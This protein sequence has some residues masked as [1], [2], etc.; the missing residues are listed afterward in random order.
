MLNAIRMVWI[1]S[2]H[3]NTDERMVPLLARIAD[4]I[5]IKVSDQIAL[6]RILQRPTAEAQATI[7]QA[8]KVLKSWL[9]NYN[10]TQE[11]ID[12]SSSEHRWQFDKKRLFE[13]TKHLT[14][15]C[16]D[17]KEVVTTL[18]H[19]HRFLGP[20][21][22]SVT[23]ET[24]AIDALVKRV[25][26]LKDPLCVA[27]FDVFAHDIASLRQWDE[28]MVKFR[29]S[30]AEVEVETTTFIDLAFH[31]L[32]SAE[33]AFDLLCGLGITAGDGVS[34][35]APPMSAQQTHG[36]PH[37]GHGAHRGRGA[38]IEA[39][40]RLKFD[41]I[42]RQYQKELVD[43]SHTFDSLKDTPPLYRNHPPVAGA[44]AWAG[45]LFQRIKTPIVRFRAMSGLLTSSMGEEVKAEY[46]VL[47]R[48]IDLYISGIYRNWCTVTVPATIELL[49]ESCIGPVP[50]GGIQ[51][52]DDVPPP[53]Y[54]VNFASEMLELIQE[55]I[56]L[57]HLTMRIPDAALNLTLQHTQYSAVRL[58]LKQVL[59]KHQALLDSLRPVELELLA[60][61]LDHLHLTL[62]QGFWPLNWTSLH[63]HT[64]IE[65]CNTELKIFRSI[66]Q[67]VRKSSDMIE[68]HVEA[69]AT[70][71]LIDPALFSDKIA[72][73]MRQLPG[74]K[75]GKGTLAERRDMASRGVDPT[76]AVNAASL[77]INEFCELI[78]IHRV[79]CTASIAARYVAMRDPMHKVEQIVAQ[80]DTGASPVLAQYYSYWEKKILAA[81]NKMIVASICVLKGVLE[82]P[83]LRVHGK[84]SETSAHI[85]LT[86]SAE[87]VHNQIVKV[88]KNV[89]SS[90]KAFP[91]WMRGTCIA[92]SKPS[93]SEA[94][95]EQEQHTFYTE[96][97][98]NPAVVRVARELQ[99]DVIKACRSVDT[100]AAAWAQYDDEHALWTRRGQM[101]MTEQREMMLQSPPTLK[102]FQTKLSRY[103]RVA[104]AVQGVPT[105]CVLGF[106][107]VDMYQLALTI[108][109]QALKWRDDFGEVL[110]E[111]ALR[112]IARIDHTMETHR[113]ELAIQPTELDELKDV[114]KAVA[115]VLARS[116]DVELRIAS[117]V[118]KCDALEYHDVPL[119][120]DETVH[121]RGLTS[122]WKKLQNDAR[123][124]DL[125]LAMTK[126]KFCAVT[127]GQTAD[128]VTRCDSALTKFKKSGPA[129]TGF[130]ADL[131]DGLTSYHMFTHMLHDF[132]K[133]K[134]DN[135]EARKLFGLEVEAI[136]S[137]TT[138]TEELD[139]VGYIYK[140]FEA[141]I[142]NSS[143]MGAML[144]EALDPNQLKKGAIATQTAWR[145]LPRSVKN[146]KHAYGLLGNTIQA[147]LDSIPLIESLKNEAMKPR[148]WAEL[149]TVTG[150]HFSFSAT[151]T[152][153]SLFK[154]NLTNFLDDINKIVGVAMQELNIEREL[155]RI[156]DTWTATNFIHSIY[157]REEGKKMAGPKIYLLAKGNEGGTDEILLE[158]DDHLLKL[159]ALG[160]K[161]EALN[162]ADQIKRWSKTLDLMVTCIEAWMK[163]QIKWLQL[164]KIFGASEDIRMQ[165]PEEAKKFDGINS[166]WIK[167]MAG[168]HDEPLAKTQCEVDGRLELL[169]SIM[170]R[171][172]NCQKS[173]SDYL[174]TK[175]AAFPRFYF[176]S[177][178]DLLRILGDSNPLSIQ[179]HLMSMFMACH[180]FKFAQGSSYIVGMS[181]PKK[182]TYAFRKQVS[183]DSAVETWLTDA[184]SEMK[185]TLRLIAKEGVF[186]YAGMPRIEWLDNQLCMVAILASQIW[187]TW[188]VEDV[189][190]SVLE[191]D[192]Y[193]MKRLL[194]AWAA[195]LDDMI[196]YVRMPS[197]TKIMKRKIGQLMIIDVHSKDLIGDFVR[198]SILDATDFFWESQLRFYWNKTTDDVEIKQCTGTFR[199]GYEYTGLLN[200][201]V[202]T[203]LTDRAY[204][205]ITQALTFR[206]GCSP[207]GPAGTGKTETTKDLAKGLGLPCYVTCCGEGLD[208]RQ[209]GQIFSG[210]CQIGAWG[211]FDEFNRINIEVL[212]VVSAQI[213]A[214]QDALNVG[215]TVVDLKIGREIK[216]DYKIGVFITM[217]P[218]YAGRT[219]LPDN[220]KAL[221]RP[222]M[223][224]VPDC[225]K[226]CLI[227]LKSQ[228]FKDSKVL[229]RKMTVLYKLASE[230]LSK[231]YHYDFA[232]RALISVLINAGM[233]L[234]REI[235]D[236][237][238]SVPQEDLVLMR[239]LRDTNKPKFV[240]DDVPLFSALIND[241]FPGLDCPRIAFVTLQD[242][243]DEYFVANQY[244]HSDCEG[245][246]SP[247]W[248][249]VDKVIQMYEI[250]QTRHSTMMVGPTGGGK[251]LVMKCLQKAMKSAFN[252]NVH[253]YV[254]N[255]KAQALTYLYGLMDP[256]TREWT[257]GVLANT[258]RMI[259]QPLQAGQEKRRNWIVY[260]GDVDAVWIEDMNS[261]M[262]D[263]RTLTLSNGERI[264]L[265]DHSIMLFETFD[266]QYA[267][268]ATISRCGMVWVDPKDLRFRP[269][270]ERWVK[271]REYTVEREEERTLLL[272]NFTNYVDKIV[273]LILSGLVDGVF[274]GR[275]EQIIPNTELSMVKQLCAL[276]DALVPVEAQPDGSFVEPLAAGDMEGIFV[277]AAMWSLGGAL[278]S[279]SRAKLAEFITTIS[280]ARLPPDAS[281]NLFDYVYSIE[282]RAWVN[283][284]TL[285]PEYVTP[286]PFEFAQILVPTVD[287]TIYLSLLDILVRDDYT[288]P[289]L[290]VG[291][292]GTAKTVTM[293]NF[294]NSHLD[295]E[296]YDS[297]IMNF[298][299]Q[300]M[301][302]DVREN[303]RSAVEKRTGRR[304]GPIGGKK[305][306]LFVDD[307]NMPEVDLYGTQ[308]PV[309]ALL[310]LLSHSK[311][312]D[313]EEDCEL[314][315]EYEDILCTAAMGPP[316]GARNAVSVY[317]FRLII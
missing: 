217:N 236:H 283:W 232:L 223:M 256:D 222:V 71:V 94:G 189:F 219:P 284:S 179:D 193:A 254:L 85:I 271:L 29:A 79:K 187:W 243:I 293:Q 109:R 54:F 55:S 150:V 12:H 145:K 288:R 156:V 277:Y 35:P 62:A 37:T 105:E 304:Y 234:G 199:Y 294:M 127:D 191:G 215:E 26:E 224:I 257:N 144:W 57:D 68:S 129:S 25:T 242:A 4:A 181:S 106:V 143:Q 289:T 190:K 151:F 308:Q 84:M 36:R 24:V 297:L 39:Q 122:E 208:F 195:K 316:G 269:Y 63:I 45:A 119:N 82:L 248:K 312:F 131:A 66:L 121:A 53:P 279:E 112:E 153:E 95:G 186:A 110:R 229:S 116:L 117:I 206:L 233:A 56:F 52:I 291:I 18:E 149:M 23:G 273:T 202:I 228:G 238:D 152:L 226:I 313:C 65:R 67:N 245:E 231:Q 218:G 230:Q 126:N 292:P 154:M 182:E 16:D 15:L 161:Q 287:N 305:L 164:D 214:I 43:V 173:L 28:L 31:Q 197:A 139:L 42:L 70:T 168:M 64:F 196:A 310:F 240:F 78:E 5:A 166:A 264:Q 220:L 2:R 69:I 295:P 89:M 239:A 285:V 216:L 32:R 207:A 50:E 317:L 73:T 177:E 306:N 60:V 97:F 100:Y 299:S 86:P 244:K 211:C 201:L 180:R 165:L 255:P 282:Q 251:T 90:C 147:F 204:M 157:S 155:K 296:V 134:D 198:D 99:A 128:L 34:P 298:S 266:L 125:R 118:N 7:A 91:R 158:L 276:L 309:T 72:E 102:F 252:L 205:T 176:K 174:N 136:H 8:K 48:R 141:H 203:P 301:A 171:L 120:A 83:L 38:A 213:R 247:Y 169:Q 75:G 76:S 101:P 183:T 270:F 267:S 221:F 88:V 108:Q 104:R 314:S 27:S 237:P 59:T 137:L 272:E 260:D 258:F 170:D 111:L 302:K 114:L 259:N 307:L 123:T 138:L 225:E 268:P 250:I 159:G 96:I 14:H 107:R 148:H 194:E 6:R 235:Q 167:M 3:Y 124:K 132:V 178:Q 81:L 209:M 74:L 58:Q 133:E 13:K 11:R 281:T 80:S 51:G 188:E 142:E 92:C 249:Q 246:N 162:F 303:F 1:I 20:Q 61:P 113:E 261:V 77:E 315:R 280:E 192:K 10:V 227:M 49:K 163:V 103:G 22:K 146:L 130:G 175:R 17:L 210:L 41:D 87:S 9:T 263:N 160:S 140:L 135:F 212:S 44:I 46:L 278:T 115:A 253:Q 172:E 300:T 184:D 274:V 262:D 286:S 290:F 311:M 185:S 30:V 47:A 33:G 265:L 98:R 93:D 200:R 19:F 241:L 40:L 21:L 275:L